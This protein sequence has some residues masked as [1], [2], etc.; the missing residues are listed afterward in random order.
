MGRFKSYKWTQFNPIKVD[1]VHRSRCKRCNHELVSN[2]D[3]YRQ[4]NGKIIQIEFKNDSALIVY[5]E[6]E[7]S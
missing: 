1:N 2:A 6:M 7:F 5:D 3:M 4:L